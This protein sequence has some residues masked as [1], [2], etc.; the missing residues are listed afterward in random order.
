MRQLLAWAPWDAALVDAAKRLVARKMDPPRPLDLPETLTPYE[1]LERFE[2]WS[3]DELRMSAEAILSLPTPEDW[4]ASA[5]AMELLIAARDTRRDSQLAVMLSGAGTDD[6]RLSQCG[7]WTFR[8]ELD[9]L[10]TGDAGQGDDLAAGLEGL[11]ESARQ[12]CSAAD[13]AE[14]LRIA[15]TAWIPETSAPGAHW[16]VPCAGGRRIANLTI[17]LQ[18]RPALSEAMGPAMDWLTEAE[19]LCGA[20]ATGGV[21]GIISA[22]EEADA[23][24]RYELGGERLLRALERS[25][26]QPDL[27]AAVAARAD[28]LMQP[29]LMAGLNAHEAVETVSEAPNVTGGAP[30]SPADDDDSDD[31]NDSV[32]DTATEAPLPQLSAVPP[33]AAPQNDWAVQLEGLATTDANEDRPPGW[34]ELALLEAAGA[35]HRAALGYLALGTSDS[36]RRLEAL[37]QAQRLRSSLD[38][39]EQL[40]LTEALFD[41]SSD[42]EFELAQDPTTWR[43][44]Y[45]WLQAATSPRLW[46][47]VRLRASVPQQ[48]ARIQ[49]PLVVGA[50]DTASTDEESDPHSTSSRIAAAADLVS[51]GRLEAASTVVSALFKHVTTSAQRQQLISI[52]RDILKDD[53]PPPGFVGA[54]ERLISAPGDEPCRLQTADAMVDALV[55]SAT[56]AY[57]LHASLHRAAGEAEALSDPQRVRLLQAWLGIWRATATPPAVDAVRKL[58]RQVPLLLALAAFR[59]AGADDPVSAA[60]EFNTR[61]P[62]RTTSATALADAL[63]TAA[64]S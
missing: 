58:S 3:S 33:P 24:G 38:D 53:A 32:L 27:I 45:A 51:A 34:A 6:E 35:G 21:A 40:R 15:A 25:G 23:T 48:W 57:P 18:R 31:Y 10:S 11:L 1:A 22:A 55:A 39:A 41:G 5:V 7:L 13:L 61:Y 47:E 8:M 62:P 9:R 12:R 16:L 29:Q 46:W 43:I 44:T 49:E 56:M 28:V 60:V 20:R 30:H 37:L 36:P 19:A 50:N 59:I 4:R 63:L 64:S 14:A 26:G 2:R 42:D 54:V 52:S 17:A